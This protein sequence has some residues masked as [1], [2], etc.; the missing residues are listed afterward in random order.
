MNANSLM[1][2]KAARALSPG[3][4]MENMPLNY[5]ALLCTASLSLGGGCRCGSLA[6][7]DANQRGGALKLVAACARRGT[8]F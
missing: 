4:E 5:G 8:D 7:R 6:A 2:G 1:P 3:R